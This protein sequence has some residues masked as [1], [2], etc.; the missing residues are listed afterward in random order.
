MISIFKK[1]LYAYRLKLAKK[2]VL[3]FAIIGNNSIV[4][5][6]SLIHI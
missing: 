5:T 4:S 3:S 1:I 2:R 6:L